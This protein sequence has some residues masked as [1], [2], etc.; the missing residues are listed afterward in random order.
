M[1]KPLALALALALPFPALAAFSSANEALGSTRHTGVPREFTAHAVH[2]HEDTHL[3]QWISGVQEGRGEWLKMRMDVTTHMQENDEFISMKMRVLLYKNMLYYTITDVNLI[4]EDDLVK[5]HLQS[6]LK[7]WVVQ[8]LPESVD[9]MSAWNFVD[10]LEAID[11][12]ILSITPAWNSVRTHTGVL[13]VEHTGYT[14]GDA[15]SITPASSA[16]GNVHIKLNA[17]K[18][19]TLQYGKY[20]LKRG[21]FVLEGSMQP[22]ASPVYL[23]VPKNTIAPQEFA[24]HM[25]GFEFPRMYGNI[26][27]P[28]E[29]PSKPTEVPAPKKTPL[30]TTPEPEIPDTRNY[31]EY[32]KRSGNAQEERVSC[33]WPGTLDAVELE[34]K[35]V[36]PTDKLTKRD[37]RAIEQQELSGK[38]LREQRVADSKMLQRYAE[39]A[40]KFEHFARTR[41]LHRAKAMLARASILD[42]GSEEVD[43]WLKN[44]ILPFFVPMLRST[45]VQHLYIEDSS[46]NTGVI[47]EKMVTMET[48]RRKSV[49]F[50]LMDNSRWRVPVV[51]DVYVNAKLHD[52][53]IQG[54]IE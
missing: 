33:A 4:T 42:V 13:N 40:S 41:E 31:V 52:L 39:I 25:L 21:T 10:I 36:C 45:V 44:D 50:I 35:G 32:A 29:M 24:M 18:D 9:S 27:L 49:V 51:T 37:I 47:L 7:K 1:F 38:E 14:G 12:D 53:L 3:A 16:D 48:G 23:D 20:Y 17:T 19:G 2:S 30:L 54:I 28:V 46:G 34:R 5:A 43:M 6:M 26:P 8:P 11:M 15:Y 22:H